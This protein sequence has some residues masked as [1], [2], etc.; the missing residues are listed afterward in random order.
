MEKR[1]FGP[2]AGVGRTG[3]FILVDTAMYMLEN[4]DP[5]YPLD[6][7]RIMRDQRPLLVQTTVCIPIGIRHSFFYFL[8]YCRISIVLLVQLY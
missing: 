7:L 4:K 8:L 6:L 5:V 3:V 1:S 2:S